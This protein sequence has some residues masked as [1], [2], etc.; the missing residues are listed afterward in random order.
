M[1]APDELRRTLSRT[2]TLTLRLT[3]HSIRMLTRENSA[4]FS[5]TCTWFGL[6]LGLGLGLGV[7]QGYG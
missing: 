7:G 1:V 3:C 5:T 2:R 6:G 4:R